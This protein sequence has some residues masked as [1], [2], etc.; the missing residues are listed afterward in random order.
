MRNL[1]H[2]AI[3]STLYGCGLRLSEVIDLK[4]E[5]IDSESEVINIR[6]AKG[7]KDRQVMLP[8]SLL[9]LLRAYFKIYLPS[10]Y[11]F[12]GQAKVKYSPRSVQAILKQA[13]L[14]AKIN[15]VVSPHV[16]RHS[17]ATHLLENGTDIRYIQKLL[18]HNNL[19]TTQ[20]Y[21]HITD[22]AKNKV[23]SPLDF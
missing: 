2:K 17:F 22:V 16:L 12:E 23:I 9:P 4:I 19:T 10:N 3:L 8:K 21:T 7:N 13:A 15:K 20:I 18:G 5:D 14:N 1:K 11:L 6:Q